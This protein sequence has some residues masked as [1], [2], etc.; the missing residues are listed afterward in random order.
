MDG[1]ART[2]VSERV[3]RAVHGLRPSEPDPAFELGLAGHLRSSHDLAGLLDLFTRFTLGDS[4]LD[5]LMRRAILRA[6]CRSFGDGV[7]IGS[8]VGIKH[9]ETF[10]IGSGVFIGAGA[11]LQGRF[12]G[13]CVIGDHVWIG[14]HAYLDARDLVIEEYVGWGPGARVLGSQ[15]TGL[16]ADVPI[17]ST[18][19]VVQSVV[20]RRGADIGT[21]AVLMPGVTVGEDAMVGAGAVVTSDVPDRAVVAGVPARVLR[22]R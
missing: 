20:V 13:R 11:Y 6:A 7:Q 12:D 15:H 19:L 3:V 16:P 8:G 17:I 10:E 4:P 9:M 2:Y 5:N 14:P 21:G 1:H 18:D 22:Y